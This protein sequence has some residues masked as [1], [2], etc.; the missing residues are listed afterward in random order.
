MQRPQA[1]CKGLLAGL[2]CLAGAA[3]ADEPPAPVSLDASRDYLIGVSVVSSAA[4]LGSDTGQSTRARPMWAFQLGRFRFASSGASALLT[5]GRQSVDTGVSTVVAG[6][7]RWSMSTSLR[8]DEGRSWDGDARLNGLPDVRG[9]LRGRLTANVA[10]G[11]RWSASVRGSQDLLGREG[12]LRI[13]SGLGYRY[14]ISS[15]THWDLSLGVGWANATHARTYYGIA[16]S[17]AQATGLP[18]YRPGAG[19][20][21]ASVGWRLTSALNRHWVMYGGVGASQL[22]GAAARSPLVGRKTVYSA[23][24][25]LAYRNH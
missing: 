15:Q 17:D 7:D 12:G 6:S 16:P 14:P 4:Q 22:Q 1:A 5:Q 25:G 13:D 8:I 9:T 24:V 10:L 2:L 23:T 3:R 11:K 21:T 20:D 19:W 18:A